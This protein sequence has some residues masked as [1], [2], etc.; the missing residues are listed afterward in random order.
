ML[1]VDTQ[2]LTALISE[3]F[4][5][6]MNGDLESDE[7]RS[8]FLVAGKQLRGCLVNLISAQF[9]DGTKDVVEANKELNQVNQNTAKL[10]QNL[11][12]TNDVLG[13]INKLVGILDGLLKIAASFH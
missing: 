3:C 7:I 12:S 4:D 5:L 11:A 6:S 1:K 13:Q 8:N 10:T 9:N 2:S